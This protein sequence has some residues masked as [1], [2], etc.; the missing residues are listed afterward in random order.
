MEIVILSNAFFVVTFLVVSH[1]QIC[2]I[3]DCVIWM[4]IFIQV[5]F[6]LENLERI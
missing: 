4:N 1:E 2:L 6:Y 3:I 5:S